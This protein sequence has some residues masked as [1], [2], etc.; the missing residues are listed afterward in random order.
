[1]SEPGP[2][3][4][5]LP[6]PLSLSLSLSLSRRRKSRGKTSRR[7]WKVE[8]EPSASG[9]STRAEATFGYVRHR[10][11]DSFLVG[12]TLGPEVKAVSS[13]VF[14]RL[15]FPARSQSSRETLSSWRTCQACLEVIVAHREF[16]SSFQSQ[17]EK[18]AKLGS[19]LPFSLDPDIL[20]AMRSF[21]SLA[22]QRPS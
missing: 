21:F 10:A 6:P 18:L 17:S 1:M 13:A 9:R 3:S 11:R 5:P 20:T 12:G 8:L 4:P 14:R 2:V 7:A 19:L 16:V 15:R 22:Q